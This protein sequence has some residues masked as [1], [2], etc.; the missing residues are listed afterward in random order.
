MEIP[1]GLIPH[2]MTK[3]ESA[4]RNMKIEGNREKF[5]SGVFRRC[6][7]GNER[8]RGPIIQLEERPVG[9]PNPEPASRV[10][11]V[12]R[13]PVPNYRLLSELCYQ[14]RAKNGR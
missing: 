8:K 3:G 11:Q 12:R 13:G 10:L 5:P 2:L 9:S 4:W 6:N 14:I 7:L 1:L